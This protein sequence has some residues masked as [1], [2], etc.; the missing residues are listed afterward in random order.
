MEGVPKFD[1]HRCDEVALVDFEGGQ[2][3][4]TQRIGIDAGDPDGLARKLE[5]IGVNIMIAGGIR[6]DILNSLNRTGINIVTGAVGKTAEGMVM[7]FMA[8]TLEKNQ[9]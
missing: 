9:L 6:Y 2:I 5:E 3:E 8:G 4:Q 7:D 1:F